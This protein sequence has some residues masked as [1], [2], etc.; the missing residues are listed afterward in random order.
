MVSLLYT[1]HLAQWKGILP[2]CG[3]FAYFNGILLLWFYHVVYLPRTATPDRFDIRLNNLL[4]QL[5]N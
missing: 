3:D 2:I 4:Q 1:Q 5:T